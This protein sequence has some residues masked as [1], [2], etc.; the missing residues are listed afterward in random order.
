MPCA[1]W[2][3]TH[4]SHIPKMCST[5][6]LPTATKSHKNKLLFT[7]NV[8]ITEQ[9]L[10]WWSCHRIN[11]FLQTTKTRMIKVL[12]YITRVSERGCTKMGCFTSNIKTRKHPWVPGNEVQILLWILAHW[13]WNG[14]DYLDPKS[15]QPARNVSTFWG[16][17]NLLIWVDW[18]Q[19]HLSLSPQNKVNSHTVYISVQDEIAE[20]KH[21]HTARSVA[22]WVQDNQRW[23]GWQSLTGKWSEMLMLLDDL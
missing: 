23:T 2:T 9:W 14:L 18:W 19:F 4:F 17:I 15:W 21:L 3:W 12:W 20:Q 7:Q 16:E 11:T 5:T 6:L 13:T 1:P 8:K 10:Y 22:H